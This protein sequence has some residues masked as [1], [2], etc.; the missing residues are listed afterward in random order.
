MMLPRRL[1][2]S[3]LLIGAAL[4][5]L[6]CGGGGGG[7]KG[8][9]PPDTTTAAPAFTAVAVGWAH[10]CGIS[11]TGYAYCWGRDASGELGTAAQV[12]VC[13]APSYRCSA[14]PLRV[15]LAPRVI[16]IAAGESYSC[17]VAV[18]GQAYCWGANSFGQ[19]GTGGSGGATPALVSSGSVRFRTIVA[20]RS[21]TCAIAT[22][23]STWCWGL[24]DRGQLGGG[25]VSADKCGTAP[26]SRVPIEV[27]GGH[28]FASLALR[29][30]ATCGLTTS[31]D[32]FCWGMGVGGADGLECQ[33]GNATDC[34][35]TPIAVNAGQSLTAIGMSDDLD[36]GLTTGGVIRCWGGTDYSGMLG[37]GT[38]GTVVTTPTDVAGGATWSSFVE[39]MASLCALDAAGNA[40]CWG[41]NSNGQLGIGAA[42]PP[43]PQ[44]TA[45]LG[46]QQ[47]SALSA[48]NLALHTCGVTKTG[49]AMCWGLGGDGQLG[50]AQTM[51][52]GAP[53]QVHSP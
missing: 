25:A 12:P 48:S 6:G 11:G 32:E 35:H 22:S 38:T 44:P 7:D 13:Q 14:V 29:D 50:N 47:F 28:T 42:S 2:A 19:L 41:S 51:S 26:C 16:G 3:P 43:V 40:K 27:V 34:T 31:G 21:H 37:N 53:V 24:D 49:E 30:G 10:S 9:T 18:G 4:L 20:S 46:S 1:C 52:S 8:I 36:C 17:A 33:Q 23:G 5:T 45:V 39:G 15:A